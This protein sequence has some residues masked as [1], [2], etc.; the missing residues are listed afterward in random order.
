ML[1][2]YVLREFE[3]LENIIVLVRD[4]KNPMNVLNTSRPTGLSTGDEKD[5]IMAMI[6]TEDTN[7]YLKIST[8]LQNTIKLYEL[9]W[10]QFSPD[11]QI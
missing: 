9:I 3:N 4:V 8:L 11:I 2:Q 6:Q 5:P 7:K 10:G 1:E